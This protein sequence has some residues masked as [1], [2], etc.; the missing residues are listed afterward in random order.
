MSFQLTVRR[1]LPALLLVLVALAG[2]TGCASTQAT[3]D[4]ELRIKKAQSHFNLAVDHANNDR[5]ELALRELLAAEKLDPKNPQIQH[6]LG[7]GY[8]R[9]GRQELAEAHLR[10][11][12]ELRPEYQDARY[13]LSTLLLS[14]GRYAECITESKRLYDDPTFTAPWRALTN[15][16]WAAYRLGNVEEG[17]E[18]LRYS[19]EYNGRYWPTHLDLGILEAEQGDTAEAIQSFER[20]IELASEPSAVA[21]ASYRIAEIFV[22]QGRR[23]EAMG[24]LRAAVDKA[25]SDPWGKK[26]EAYLKKLR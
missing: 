11:A 12:L 18:H 21:E 13:N 24:H 20:V 6:A 4:D 26:S 10:A 7:I 23:E 17:R 2:A 16:G 19:R 5:L 9:K 1:G 8:L 25:P 15:W 3:R 22:A 14:Q